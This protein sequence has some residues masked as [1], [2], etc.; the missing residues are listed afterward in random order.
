ML[1]YIKSRSSRI[2]WL[3][4]S[5]VIILTIKY[6]SYDFILDILSTKLL[7]RTNY[8]GSSSFGGVFSWQTYV[9]YHFY[10]ANNIHIDGYRGKYTATKLVECCS[11]LRLTLS[12]MS[13]C[14]ETVAPTTSSRLIMAHFPKFNMTKP[15]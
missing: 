12:T 2:V 7:F 14:N 10:D 13:L 4:Y 11:R 8:Y 5:L 6:H 1:H 15:N 3:I 9:F